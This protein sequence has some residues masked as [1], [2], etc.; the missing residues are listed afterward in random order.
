VFLTV[1][2]VDIQ[3]GLTEYNLDDAPIKRAAFASARRRIV[4]ADSTKLGKAAFARIAPIEQLDV[5]VTDS[6]ASPEFLH[7]IAEAGVEVVTA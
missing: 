5:L 3:H 7:A 2:G 6:D 1:G 4:V